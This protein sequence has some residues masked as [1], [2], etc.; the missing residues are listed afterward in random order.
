MLNVSIPTLSNE[1]L[2]Y[3]IREVFTA[4]EPDSLPGA[5]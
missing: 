4:M 3:C 1:A 2:L 5:M